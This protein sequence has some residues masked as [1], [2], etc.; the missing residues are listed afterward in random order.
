MKLFLNV[1][2]TLTL[3]QIKLQFSFG[4][5]VCLFQFSFFSFLS[6][7]NFDFFIWFEYRD[8]GLTPEIPSNCPQKLVELIQM[9]WKKQPQQ[10]PVSFLFVFVFV[11]VSSFYNK[12]NKW[13]I[14]FITSL[15]E[16][17][18]GFWNNLYNVGTIKL[19]FNAW[20]QI[21]NNKNFAVAVKN[22]KF[23]DW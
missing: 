6:W 20:N 14:W 12:P 22:D 21:S 4:E 16:M 8:K 23:Y 18:K 7:Q 9:C 3:I 1:N 5:F 19:Q 11:S 13:M 2:L 17:L 15:I 10:R